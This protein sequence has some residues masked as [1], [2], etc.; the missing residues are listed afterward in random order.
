METKIIVVSAL[1][2]G[3]KFPQAGEETQFQSRKFEVAPCFLLEVMYRNNVL[4]K[5]MWDEGKEVRYVYHR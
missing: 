4:T 1:L 3:R 2:L 5:A